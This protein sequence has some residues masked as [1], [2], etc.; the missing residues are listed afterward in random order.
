MNVIKSENK[1]WSGCF[2]VVLY[3]LLVMLGA[4]ICTRKCEGQG[5]V[6]GLFQPADLGIGARVDYYPLKIR[7]PGN[8][9]AGLY[10]SI[11]YGS[12]GLYR[13]Y[14]LGSHVKVG[15]GALIPLPAYPPFRHVL[16]LGVNYHYLSGARREGSEVS[17]KIFRP[18]SFEAGLS[19]Y[20]RRLAVA[21]NTDILRWE[22]SI[23][24]GYVF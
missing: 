1:L 15:A 20:M 6:Y 4:A 3:V 16:S 23:G 11:A 7:E 22:P 13:L 8:Q 5:A 2:W 12:G 21:V 24:I 10:H 9:R 17:W 18:W 14:G 19:V